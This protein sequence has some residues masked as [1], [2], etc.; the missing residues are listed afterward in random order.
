MDDL[1]I[2]RSYKLIAIRFHIS[3]IL[4]LLGNLNLSNKLA[5]SALLLYY[6]FTILNAFLEGVSMV[7]LVGIFTGGLVDGN[8]GGVPTYISEITNVIGGKVD[9]S[10]VVLLLIALFSVNLVI[11]FGLL[12]FDGVISALLRRRI[13]EAI[14]SR[15]LLGDWSHM[16]NFRV[17]N[18]V[19]TNTQ[20]ALVVSKYLTSVVSTIYFI[21]GAFV[22]S[23]L[24]IMTSFKMSLLLGLIALPLGWLMQKTVSIQSQLSKRSAAL[25]ND[26]SSDITDRFNGLLQVH[27]EHNYDFHLR[28]GLQAQDRL[29]TVDMLIGVCQAVIGS[30]NLLLPLTALIGFSAWLFIMGGDSASNLALIA[31]VGVLGIRVAGQLNG[32]VASVGNLSRLSGGLYP[33]LDALSVP[34]ISVRRLIDEPVV[35]VEMDRVRYAYG[36]H[37]VID[38]ATLVAEKGLPLV[39]SGRSGKGKTTLANLIAGLYSPCSGSLI[40]FAASGRAFSSRDYRARVGFVTQD[41]YLFRGSLRCNLAAGRDCTDEQIWAALERVDAAEFVRTMGGL[42]TESTEAGRSLSGGQRRRLGIARILLSGS[43]I[44]IFDEA[45]AGL[46]QVNKSAVLSVIEQLSE[47]YIVVIISHEELFLSRQKSYLV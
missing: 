28:Q 30:F 37:A 14:F 23:G 10:G 39:L 36:G 31:S 7:I 4:Q 1:Y 24:A 22:L 38:G 5:L 11:R 32:A 2:K 13:Q 16:R 44:L 43:D 12:V 3:A 21:L 42:D 27:I 46:D 40:Y 26:F 15:Y 29:T 33:V 45:T 25:R 20:E 47:N 9:L 19:G 41:I 18:A 35:R 17:G 6:L 34:P 8:K